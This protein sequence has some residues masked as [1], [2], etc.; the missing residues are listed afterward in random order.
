MRANRV[1]WPLVL[2]VVGGLFLLDNLH[3]LTVSVWGVVIPVILILGGISVLIGSVSRA[4]RGETT[5]L[6]IPLEG[7]EQAQVK[8]KYGAGK[9]TLSGGAA[10]GE[11]LS[12]SFDSGVEHSARRGG[13]G[14]DVT[15]SGPTDFAGA[16]PSS[17]SLPAPYDTFS[18]A[19]SPP[20]S[21]IVSPVVSPC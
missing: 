13:G 21:G 9:L 12:G 2:I 19:V 1:F 6:S 8:V 14:L 20:S 16:P 5:A 10:S 3:I 18:R 11:L 4:T 17:T 15:L 7:S